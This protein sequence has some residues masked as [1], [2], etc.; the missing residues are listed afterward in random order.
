[1][2][3]WHDVTTPSPRRVVVHSPRPADEAL[4]ILANLLTGEPRPIRSRAS[5]GIMLLEGAVDTRGVAFTVMPRTRAAGPGQPTESR[6]LEFVGAI[7]ATSDGSMLTGSISA[8]PTALGLP[9]AAIAAL[10]AL[11]LIW[12]GIPLPLVAVGVVAWIFL[13]VIVVAGIGEQR[14]AG[15]D[16]IGRLLED[17]L[18]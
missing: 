10:V 1:V 6:T 14:L 15:A 18:A 12:N 8:P 4:A 17:A 11:F 9:A 3:L 5:P 13:T 2:S 7:E 16:S